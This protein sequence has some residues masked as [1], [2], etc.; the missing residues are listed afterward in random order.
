MPAPIRAGWAPYAAF[1]D[2]SGNRQEP[3]FNRH[4]VQFQVWQGG[5]R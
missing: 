5:I 2:A 1:A 3:K 4:L